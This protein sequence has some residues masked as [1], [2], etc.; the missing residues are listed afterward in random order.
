MAVRT[1]P[2]LH[3]DGSPCWT[4]NCSRSLETFIQQQDFNG[5]LN[6]RLEQ[7]KSP[8]P[9]KK[10]KTISV[11][12]NGHIAI[13]EH[14]N[15]D[16]LKQYETVDAVKPLDG[17]VGRKD[18]IFASPSIQGVG[19][20]VKA[21]ESSTRTQGLD[22]NE[23]KVDPKNVYVYSIDEYE[24]AAFSLENQNNPEAYRDYWAS[25]IL[26]SD[27]AEEAGRKNLDASKWEILLP[28]TDIIDVR[29]MSSR[30]VI[31]AQE[32]GSYIRREL[33]WAL[34]PKKASKSIQW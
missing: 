7:E 22:N 6:A 10:P 25:G 17:R 33:M 32:E 34:E 9:T 29:T 24:K 23:I 18:A 20:W 26:L 14:K 28:E 19:R 15:P 4:K 8:K 16:V 3:S 1:A 2:Y 27:W 21:N 13:A 31:M 5:Y 12:R 11:Y 30:R